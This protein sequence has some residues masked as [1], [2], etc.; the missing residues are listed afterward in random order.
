MKILV[1][2]SK[3]YIGAKVMEELGQAGHQVVGYDRRA[4][5]AQDIL[6]RAQLAGVMTGCERVVH[7][8][9]IPWPKPGVAWEN[10]WQQNCMGV[11]NVA[12]AAVEAGVKRVV[13]TSSTAYYGA[14]EGFQPEWLSGSVVN[15]RSRNATQIWGPGA[16]PA[17]MGEKEQAGVY[18]MCSKVIA[19][20]ILGAYGLRRALEVVIL[21]LCPTSDDAAPWLWGLYARRW[22]VAQVIRRMVEEKRELW[23]E[24]FNVAEPDVQVL[25][26]E[27]L[28][29]FVGDLGNG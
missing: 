6:D 11:N 7:L 25:S 23:Y 21:R 13:Y 8:A 2:G 26:T 20:G 18:Y 16:L 15:E 3:G 22:R 17:V 19:E 1:T 5:E 9:A 29:R 14:E 4:D 12:Q 24:V 28:A 10:F 27:K